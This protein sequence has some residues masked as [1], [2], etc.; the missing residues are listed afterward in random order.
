MLVGLIEL[1]YNLLFILILA[2]IILSFTQSGHYH[3]VGRAIFNATEPLLAPIRSM[4]PSMN[5]IDFSPLVLLLAA[6][7]LRMV[8]LSLVA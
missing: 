5:G 4:L 3:P 2:R 6:G 8:L 7:L 1:L